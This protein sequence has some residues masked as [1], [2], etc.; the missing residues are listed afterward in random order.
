[1]ELVKQ[2]YLRVGV[3]WHVFPT[4]TEAKDAVWRDPAMLFNIIP[5]EMIQSRNDTE[6][7]VEFKNGSL[8]QLKGADKPER[9]LGSGPMGVVLDEFAEMK[10]ET[11]QRIVE[12]ILRAN[13]GWCWFVGTPK[14]KN[15]LFE[16]YQR[17]QQPS[18]EWRSWRV[19]SSESGVIS[20]DQLI[21]A[22]KSMTQSLYNQEMEC[23]FLEGEGSVFRGVREIMTADYQKPYPDHLYV[24][25]IDLAKV[26]DYT[27][28]SIFD[29]QRNNQVYQERFNKLEWP[30]QKAKIKSIVDHYNNALAVIDSTGL[31]DPIC[32]DLTRSGIAVNAFKITEQTKKDL[33]EKLSIFIEQK[34][35]KLLPLDESIFEY[36]NFSYEIGKTGKIRYGALEGFNDDIVLSHA[37][38]VFSLQNLLKPL[39]K[40]IPSVIRQEYIRQVQERGQDESQGEYMP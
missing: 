40:A 26:T 24:A 33:I 14:G 28:V 13:G 19:R 17:G 3:Y 5:P 23:D 38:A 11:W 37:L 15:H 12:P 35:I 2:A 8:L 22:K 34:N 16:L 21:E 39:P 6:L 29:R 1:M 32:D 4:Y 7:I 31:G 20:Q 9:L 10:F 18:N 30:Y 36:D 27:V 25:G